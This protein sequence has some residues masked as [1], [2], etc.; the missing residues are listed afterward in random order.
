MW[1]RFQNIE[2]DRKGVERRKQPLPHGRGSVAAVQSREPLRGFS[3]AE[4]RPARSTA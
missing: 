3:Q 1:A 4:T 2:P